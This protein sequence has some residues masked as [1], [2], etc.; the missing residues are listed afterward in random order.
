[1]G[2]SSATS[3]KQ[4]QPATSSRVRDIQEEIGSYISATHEKLTNYGYNSR[5]GL[6]GLPKTPQAVK[7]YKSAIVLGNA[8]ALN[9]PGILMTDGIDGVP[10]D[11]PRA[12]KLIEDAVAKGNSS[13]MVKLVQTM[14]RQCSQTTFKQCSWR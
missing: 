5:N 11:V 3:S 7:M 9:N 13:A 8:G 4:K 14:F 1:M 10:K 12:K 2:T 6:N